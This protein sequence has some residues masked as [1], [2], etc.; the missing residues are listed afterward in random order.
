MKEHFSLEIDGVIREERL[1]DY[2]LSED[3]VHFYGDSQLRL[4]IE[5]LIQDQDL[6]IA[7]WTMLM[8]C[9]RFLKFC[10]LRN[11]QDV[12]PVLMRK[13]L[14]LVADAANSALEALNKQEAR[15]EN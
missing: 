6:C 1:L 9:L 10:E 2:L 12:P 14:K 11:S 5:A 13:S 3:V 7:S 15:N 4:Q 8:R